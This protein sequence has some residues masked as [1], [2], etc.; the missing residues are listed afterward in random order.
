M[1]FLT[2]V[3]REA[4]EVKYEQNYL[5][6]HFHHLNFLHV[7]VLYVHVWLVHHVHVGF[8]IGWLNLILL[9]GARDVMK[10]F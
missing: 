6:G 4:S 7:H 2:R 5:V 1:C 9:T 8:I 10:N 3:E